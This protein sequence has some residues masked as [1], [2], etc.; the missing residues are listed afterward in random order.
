MAE[1]TGISRTVA[2]QARDF[3]R[4][5]R[6]GEHQQ[7]DAGDH[8]GGRGQRADGAG[9]DRG[10]AVHPPL[11]EGGEDRRDDVEEPDHERGACR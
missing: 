5:R 4:L 2:H 3:P 11:A 9:E 6:V 10:E 1:P 7:Q 8:G